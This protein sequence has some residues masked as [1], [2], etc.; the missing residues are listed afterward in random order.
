MEEGMVANS[1]LSQHNPDTKARE[2]HHKKSIQ[3][4]HVSHE[5]RCKNSKQSNIN[6][7]QVSE[8]ENNTPNQFCFIRGMQG[9]LNIS[10]IC[11]CNSLIH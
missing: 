4:T 8:K 9:L 2:K 5:Y 7:I 10:K 3:Q 6:K 11:K 1:F